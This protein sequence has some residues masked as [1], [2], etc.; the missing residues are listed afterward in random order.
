MKLAVVYHS[1]SGNTKKAAEYVKTGMEQV[2]GVEVQCLSIEEADSEKLADVCGVAFGAPT[3]YADMSWQMLQYL[4]N[5]KLNLSDKLGC[6]YSTANFPQGGSELVLQNINTVL[7]AKG[8]LVY[9]G[10]TSHGVPF[11]HVGANAFTK[12]G[13]IDA[14]AEILS[15]L[16]KKFAEKAV[17]IFG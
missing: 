17:E 15:A 2:E 9:A 7:L 16:G 14:R 3:Y 1:V 13:G 6:A 4:E 11:T 10:G 5:T 8:M 12:D